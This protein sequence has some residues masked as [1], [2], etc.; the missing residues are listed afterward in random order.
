MGSQDSSISG[1]MSR[2]MVGLPL[3]STTAIP[4]RTISSMGSCPSPS[5]R[6]L[7]SN[8]FSRNQRS[9][10]RSAFFRSSRTRVWPAHGFSSSILSSLAYTCFLSRWRSRRCSVRIARIS[11]SRSSGISGRESRICSISETSFFREDFQAASTMSAIEL[12]RRI[13]WL[14]S[15]ALESP[16][17]TRLISPA[18]M[19]APAIA[20]ATSAWSC[21]CRDM[22]PISGSIWRAYCMISVFRCFC[23]Y[24]MKRGIISERIAERYLRMLILSKASAAFSM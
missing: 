13:F 20:R 16:A 11:V 12:V 24:R 1:V 8:A 15:A 10:L 22:S 21:D 5:R 9:P 4:E 18:S 6:A 23:P 14:I 3:F 17:V 19:P 2:R 7:N